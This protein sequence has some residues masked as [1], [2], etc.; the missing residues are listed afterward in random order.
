MTA[1]ARH[2]HRLAWIATLLAFALIVFGAF[3]RLSNAGLS[4]PDWPTCYGRATWPEHEHEIATANAQYTRVVETH[5]TWREQRH[6]HLAGALGLI[7]LVLALV[8]ARKRPQGMALVAGASTLVGVSIPLYM[9]GHFGFA[10]AAA[11]A[12]EL[13]LLACAWRWAGGSDHARIATVALMLVVF[14]AVLGM[15]TVTWLL[16]PI[17]VMGHL[18]GG[19]GL[20]ALLAWLSWRASPNGPLVQ[21]IAP[22]LRRMLWVALALVALQI[23]LGGWTSANYAALSCGLEFPTCIGQWW[24]AA[25]FREGF[26]LWRGIGVD[27]EG[28]V[29]DGPARVAIQLAHRAVAVLVFGHLAMVGVRSRRRPTNSSHANATTAIIR[30]ASWIAI[31]DAPSSTPPS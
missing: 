23:A 27:Y 22:K 3:V 31:R 6:R 4:C 25:D 24:P 5:K 20:F 15:W 9:F 1:S 12:G 14:Q 17:V 10:A 11:L 2:F 29:L 13:L 18:L 26:V 19:M 7:I 8:A 21:G 30:C 28:G 16:K